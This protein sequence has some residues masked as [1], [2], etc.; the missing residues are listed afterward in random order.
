V[1]N[2]EHVSCPSIIRQALLTIDNDTFRVDLFVMLLAG[3]DLVLGMQ[4]LA[5]L[6]PVLWDF[7]ARKMSF[8]RQGRA[9]CW[10]GVVTTSA[11][12]VR[13][14]IASESL[15]DEL[16]ASFG[17]VFAEPQGLPPPRAH[18]HSIVLKPSTQP[19]AV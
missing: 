3:Y 9:V 15:L 5:T 16:L 11:P 17:D 6:G 10:T 7:N 19:V 13:T 1:A 2:G 4:W 18:N 8:Q 12:D 14:T